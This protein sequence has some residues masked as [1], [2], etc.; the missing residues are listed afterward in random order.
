LGALQFRGFNKIPKAECDTEFANRKL[1]RQVEAGEDAGEDAGEETKT[2]YDYADEYDDDPN[3][4]GPC[5]LYGCCDDN[6]RRG[7]KHKLVGTAMIQVFED[8]GNPE[9][10]KFGLVNLFGQLHRSANDWMDD[11]GKL[12][13]GRKKKPNC[14]DLVVAVDDKDAR[15]KYLK[16]ALNDFGTKLTE[17]LETTKLEPNDCRVLFAHGMGTAIAGGMWAEKLEG[18]KGTVWYGKYSERSVLPRLQAFANKFKGKCTFFLMKDPNWVDDAFMEDAVKYTKDEDATLKE[19]YTELQRLRSDEKTKDEAKALANKISECTRAHVLHGDK[20]FGEC[21]AC[22][23]EGCRSCYGK[24]N[25]PEQELA[26]C[27]Q[28]A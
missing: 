25:T 6:D 27:Q 2:Y 9:G 28:V 7:V 10:H 4:K 19:N 20:S 26:K 8:E 1:K 16:S 18:L 21:M 11:E 22:K 23:S 14:V 5:D 13:D 3:K 24:P 15:A 12:C 17:F